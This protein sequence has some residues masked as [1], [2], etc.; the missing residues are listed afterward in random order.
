MTSTTIPKRV[1]FPYTFNFKRALHHV[2]AQRVCCHLTLLI[3][4]QNPRQAAKIS[5]FFF[6][7]ACSKIVGKVAKIAGVFAQF[8]RSSR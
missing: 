6:P 3:T 1:I 8:A 7:P 2:P 4:Q 5:P